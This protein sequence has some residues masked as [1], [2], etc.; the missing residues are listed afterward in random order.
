[1][2]DNIIEISRDDDHDLDKDHGVIRPLE[3]TQ[4]HIKQTGRSKQNLIVLI[5]QLLYRPQVQRARRS[6]YDK[7]RKSISSNEF[8]PAHIWLKCPEENTSIAMDRLK[9]R[10]RPG[11]GSP[12]QA[13]IPKQAE[14]A[15]NWLPLDLGPPSDRDRALTTPSPDDYMGAKRERGLYTNKGGGSGDKNCSD[16]LNSSSLC[17]SNYLKYYMN[18]IMHRMRINEFCITRPRRR[19]RP[20]KGLSYSFSVTH[21]DG[22][23]RRRRDDDEDEEWPNMSSSEI[24]PISERGPNRKLINV[25]CLGMLLISLMA[26]CCLPMDTEALL[27]EPNGATSRSLS[28]YNF[29]DWL[30]SVG[31]PDHPATTGIGL[32]ASSNAVV[33]NG[34]P[35]PNEQPGGSSNLID[36]SLVPEVG[37]LQQQ[38]SP[39]SQLVTA[40]GSPLVTLGQP[41]ELQP[42]SQMSAMAT[43]GQADYMETAASKK[44]KK[45]KMMKKKKKMEKKHKE[46]KKGKKHKKKKYESK[47]KKGGSSKKKK[48]LY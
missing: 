24:A 2:D 44:K 31:L 35:R 17:I 25:T 14:V 6:K 39:M 1:M 16:T 18:V 7:Q 36:V 23:K 29:K 32:T 43:I 45:M 5:K 30:P 37:Q 11:T 41:G 33:F 9:R 20:L 19:R 38:V 40:S 4:Q 34:E 21:P 27:M 22:S 46:W 48:G 28:S 15:R 10:P 26:T 12:G 8:L 3:L 47:K 42:A 13:P